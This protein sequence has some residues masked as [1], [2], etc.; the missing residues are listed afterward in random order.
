MKK[1]MVNIMGVQ[2]VLLA[3]A[4]PIAMPAL[5]SQV[6]QPVTGK[7]TLMEL[8]ADWCLPC[9]MMRP[10]LEGMQK[11]YPKDLKV[12]IVDVSKEKEAMIKY[13]VKVIPTQIFFDREGN[14]VKRHQ[15]FLP[16]E[17]IQKILNELK[18]KE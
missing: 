8:G 4:L 13:G 16:E 15:G 12:L 14:E 17:K 5:A 3:M 18:V 11:K 7:V 1:N 2:M 6:P 10:I 9:K